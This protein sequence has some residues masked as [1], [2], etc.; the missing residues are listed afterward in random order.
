[1][2][3]LAVVLFF[4]G[5]QAPAAPHPGKNTLKAFKAH[6]KECF[7]GCGYYPHNIPEGLAVGVAFGAAQPVLMGQRLTQRCIGTG[8]WHPKLP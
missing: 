2:G 5:G 4:P 7:A 8:Y 3:F 1:M 6:G